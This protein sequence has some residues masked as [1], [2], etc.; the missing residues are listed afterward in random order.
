MTPTAS[1]IERVDPPSNGGERELLEAFLD[2]H[3][4][5][6]LMKC[7]DLDEEQLKRA[8]V[9]P[10]VLSL[11]ALVRHL[12]EVE[13]SWFCERVDGQDEADLP[14]Y[15]HEDDMDADFNEAPQADPAETFERY[16]SAVE[17]ARRAAAAHGLDDTHETSRRGPTSLRWVYLHMIEEY[18]RHNGHADFIRERI[19]GAT[20]E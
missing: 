2:Y 15:G 11:L 12:T 5:T 17:A 1:D 6:L 19:D 7:A 9:E 16:R 4:G 18:A 13:L 8:S 3:R 20:G 10:S 14:Y